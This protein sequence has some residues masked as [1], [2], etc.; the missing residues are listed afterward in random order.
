M[1]KVIEIVNKKAYFEYH[2]LDTWNAGI[3]LTGTEI[4]SVRTGK[5]NLMDGYCFFQKGEL[6]VKNLHINEYKWGN[7]YNHEPL[8]IRKLLLNKRELKKL[9]SKVKERGFTIIPISMY[10]TDRGLAKIEIALVKGKKIYDKRNNIKQKD[11]N[12]EL[13]RNKKW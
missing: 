13:D 6:W 9:D 3:M 12:R 7:H 1:E 11:V 8:R 4:K 5:V 10:V 2:V